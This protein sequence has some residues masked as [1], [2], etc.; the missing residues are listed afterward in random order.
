LDSFT[1]IQCWVGR[2]SN[3]LVCVNFYI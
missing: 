2:A 3:F 1:G